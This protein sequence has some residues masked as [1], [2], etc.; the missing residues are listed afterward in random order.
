MSAE[1]IRVTKPCITP[2]FLDLEVTRVL[3]RSGQNQ[4]F[5]ALLAPRGPKRASHTDHIVR[6]IENRTL[7]PDILIKAF[8]GELLLRFVRS[9]FRNGKAVM[10]A[11]TEEK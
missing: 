3:R 4:V 8:E 11:F 5:S 6:G 1:L 7:P 2:H 10:L 9:F